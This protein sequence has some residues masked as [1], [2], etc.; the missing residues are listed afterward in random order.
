MSEMSVTFPNG[1]ISF[2][3]DELSLMRH[4]RA[5]RFYRATVAYRTDAVEREDRDRDP[6]FVLACGLAFNNVFSADEC[7][8]SE[9]RK[10]AVKHLLDRPL[11]VR[12]YVG[13]TVLSA[14]YAALAKLP[15]REMLGYVPRRLVAVFQAMRKVK[16]SPPAP[17]RAKRQ[18]SSRQARSQYAK[19]RAAGH[20][21]EKAVAM[22]RVMARTDSSSCP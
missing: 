7:A 12:L 4:G 16:K 5:P 13:Q 9:G 14:V 20:S 21:H 6:A 8:K 18:V 1:K 10:F 11:I 2:A 22:C 19:L 3:R 17:A 15:A